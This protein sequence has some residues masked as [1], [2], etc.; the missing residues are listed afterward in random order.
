M[1]IP[2]GL[3]GYPA[4]QLRVRIAG[5]TYRGLTEIPLDL[6]DQVMEAAIKQLETR[7]PTIESAYLIGTQNAKL[8]Y[9]PVEEIQYYGGR[10]LAHPS[11]I[12]MKKIRKWPARRKEDWNPYFVK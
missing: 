10:D 5:V 1:E 6:R 9:A 8:W 7:D 12:G 3:Q 2:E 4:E 11:G